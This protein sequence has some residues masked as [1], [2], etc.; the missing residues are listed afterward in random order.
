LNFD[1]VDCVEEAG[2]PRWCC[3]KES[4]YQCR[5]CQRPGFDPE[6]ISGVGN[7]N[8]LWYSCLENSMDRGAWQATAMEFQRV[9]HDL[10]IEH[11]QSSR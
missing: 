5:R 10:V 4:V 3:A 9:E 1:C 11:T 6:L 2:I 7:C 8:S